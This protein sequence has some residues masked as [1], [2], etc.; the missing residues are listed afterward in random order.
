[1]KKVLIFLLIIA[2]LVAFGWFYH[3]KAATEP[4]AEAADQPAARVEVAPLKM[5]SIVQTLDVFGV[6]ATA[7]SG[8]RV[9]TAAFDCIVR[10]VNIA[11]G[12]RISIGEV[13]L[14]I[15]PSPEAQL[16]LES[17]RSALVSAAKSLSAAKERFD[18]KLATS[19]ELRM[20]EQAELEARQKNNSLETRGLRSDGRISAPVAGVVGKLDAVAGSAIS[21][22]TALMTITSGA[23]LEV[24]LGIEVSDVSK[25]LP[26]QKVTLISTHR[27]GGTPITSTVRLTGGAL[28]AVSGSVDVRV[29]LPPDAELLQG[30]HVSAAIE[31]FSKDALVVPRSAVLPDGDKRVIF[32]S[33]DGRAVRHEVTLGITSGNLAEV[34]GPD[35]REGDMVV[36]LGNYEL[37]AGMAIQP[38]VTKEKAE[39]AKP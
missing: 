21:A 7:P 27:N 36:S 39:E 28:D 13:L 32:T 11:P 34:I 12:A 25:V 9:L 19:E 30:E 17:A 37:S 2:G 22:G 6:V 16:Q 38:P 4:A 5:Q 26:G 15:E 24:R 1:M 23:G 29:P 10:K 20:A 18:L 35:L 8:D 31:L 14:E 3:K 33:K